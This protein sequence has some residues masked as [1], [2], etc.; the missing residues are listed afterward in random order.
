MELD[1][2][3]LR[4][5]LLQCEMDAYEH[6][7]TTEIFQPQ[8]DTYR[9][10]YPL[11]S[12]HD[13]VTFSKIVRGMIDIQKHEGWLPECRGA[14][15]MHFIQGGSSKFCELDKLVCIAHTALLLD[16]DP[17]LGEFFVK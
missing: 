14:T 15:A 11:M 4:L 10:L 6:I 16:A 12:L 9:T 8:W 3:L 17:I 7:M 5:P 2:T 13:P 1:R